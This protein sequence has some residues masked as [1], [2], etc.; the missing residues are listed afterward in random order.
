[1]HESDIKKLKR[2]I[3]ANFNRA[4]EGLRVCEDI[5]R[6]IYDQKNFTRSFK[7]CRHDLTKN[8]A[9]LSLADIIQSRDIARDVGRGSTPSEFKRSTVDDVFN[10]NMQRVKESIRV[11]EEC[12]KLR[13]KRS[14]QELKTLRYKIYALEKKII[15]RR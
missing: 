4:K 7:N 11:L 15:E 13:N 9:G 10:A 6:F 1:M 2:L 14:A 5:C 3:D 12:A 8:V